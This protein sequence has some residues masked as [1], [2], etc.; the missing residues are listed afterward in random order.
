[1]TEKAADQT[2]LNRAIVSFSFPANKS[3][4]WYDLDEPDNPY[5][6][7]D[8]GGPYEFRR[9][10]G[11]KDQGL[12]CELFEGQV[13]QSSVRRDGVIS[14]PGK[15]WFASIDLGKRIRSRVGIVSASIVILS[16][17]G[18]AN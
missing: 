4:I 9:F 7:A 14:V 17:R 12:V 3:Y 2:K 5:E 8:I 6:D 15:H 13:V 16:R 11:E 18:E 1:M 10:L